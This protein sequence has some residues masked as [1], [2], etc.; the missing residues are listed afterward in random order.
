MG[1]VGVDWDHGNVV[2]VKAGV[3]RGEGGA[4]VGNVGLTVTCA[5]I[6][7]SEAG[8][9]AVEASGGFEFGEKGPSLNERGS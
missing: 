3:G 4:G 7:V 9:E 2:R 8:D 1:K 5:M 6:G